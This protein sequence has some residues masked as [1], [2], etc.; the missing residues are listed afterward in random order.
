MT[1]APDGTLVPSACHISDY[2]CPS[3]TPGVHGVGRVNTDIVAVQRGCRQG[4]VRELAKGLE[5]STPCLQD[6]CATDCATPAG[7][8]HTG[9]DSPGVYA[10]LRD[11]IRH[12]RD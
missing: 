5:P 9:A 12:R 2:W 11:G 10:E 1:S 8:R 3:L 7:P 6:R 4:Q